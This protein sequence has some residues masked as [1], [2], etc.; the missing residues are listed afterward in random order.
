VQSLK[1]WQQDY[2]Y[3][4]PLTLIKVSLLSLFNLF[5][6]VSLLSTFN[7]FLKWKIGCLKKVIVQKS[8]N[9]S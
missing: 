8:I 7:L 4:I 9:S 5:F 3:N 6:D 2:I 1:I